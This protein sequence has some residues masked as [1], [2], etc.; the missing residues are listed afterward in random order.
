MR[1]NTPHPPRRPW[2]GA[3]TLIE[4]L[5]VIAIIAI[6]AAI[7]FPVFA[8][9]R[10]KAR[11]ASCMSNLR[12]IGAAALMYVQDYDE[13]FFLNSYTFTEG[14]NLKNQGWY[15]VYDFVTQQ[16]FP[17]RGLLQPYMKN[18]AIQ[19]CPS[20][21]ELTDNSPLFVRSQL[22]YG[23]NV[24]GLRLF[25]PVSGPA[26]GPATLGEMTAPAETVLLSE[27]AQI[28]KTN[29]T[30]PATLGRSPIL[31]RPSR[32]IRPTFHARHNEFG[33]VL[34][35]DGHVKAFKPTYRTNN[36][37]IYSAADFRRFNLGDLC[38]PGSPPNSTNN[39]YFDLR[40]QQ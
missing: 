30:A 23:L 6:L 27:A 14:G 40:K 37:G 18:V 28:S 22:A 2:T 7:L 21:G 33:N 20:A 11:Q 32:Q 3:F 1:M 34:W 31:E 17:E 16:T 38:P 10:E 26:I 25:N 35:C 8:Q 24:D 4:L 36:F 39:Y 12:N 29:A 13:T 19:D 15:S 9:A 5:V